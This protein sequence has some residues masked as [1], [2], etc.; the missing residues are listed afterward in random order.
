MVNI[1]RTRIK[2]DKCHVKIPKMQPKLR[3]TICDSIKHLACQKLTKSD[4]NDIIR[5]KLNWTCMECISDILPINACIPAKTVKSERP[6]I[7]KVKC[8]ACNGFCYSVKNLR[9]CDYCNS[10]VHVKCWRNGLGC[11]KCCENIIP[12]FYAYSYELIGDPYYKNNKMYNPYDSGHFTQLIGDMLCEDDESN[13]AFREASE[14]LVNCKYK[15]SGTIDVPSNLELS[16]FSLNISTLGNKIEILR[17]NISFYGNFDVLLFNETNCIVDK[18]ANGENDLELEGFYKPIIEDPIR[19]SGKGGGLSIYINKR[20]CA[21]EDDIELFCPY[22]DPENTS[23]EFQFVKIKKCKGHQKTIILGNVYRSP[24]TT[25]TKFNTYFDKILEKLNNKRYSNKLIYI[26]GDFNQ[27]LIKY[28]NDTDCQ[29]LVDSAH[30]NGFIQLVSRPTRITE[31]T[32]TLID[33]TFTNNIDSVLSCNIITADL[34]DHL[35]IQTKI[36][37]GSS[38][39]ESRTTFNKQDKKE[40]RIFTEANNQIFEQLIR[41]EKWEEIT[42][43]LGA[44]DSYDKLEEIYMKHYNTAYPLKSSRILRNHERKDPKPW[45]LPWLEDACARKNKLYY[46]FVKNPS[47]ENK[48]KYAKLDKFCK[49]HI[50]NAKIKYRK[51]YFEKYKDDSRKQWQMINE[52]LGRKRK[53]VSINKLV[54][55]NGNISSTPSSIANSFNEY[56]SK[57]ASNLKSN[58]ADSQGRNG[59]ENYHQTYLKNSVSDTLF[60]S[61]VDASEVYEVIKNFKNKSTRDTKICSLKL[62]NKSFTFTSTVASVI[63]KSFQE[64]VFPEQMKLARVTPIYKEGAKIDVGNYRPISILNS[65]SKIYEKLMHKRLSNFLESNDSIYEN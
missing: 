40:F 47:S 36:T 46:D 3:C 24:S 43:N 5:L 52:L 25:P 65:F 58:T 49:K 6:T 30:N 27:D 56:F 50:N 2:C 4:A 1:P 10:Q 14:L 64:G 11:I 62:A 12:G 17:E 29:N 39:R 48:A 38:T 55:C 61:M 53:S 44:Q 9:T 26:V 31:R 8:S 59:D 32:A 18:L 35:A 60:L 21:D 63:N 16:I 33:L 45:I 15:I 57:I 13:S 19:K 22:N 54:D 7:F 20:V 34:S 51:S 37:L 42:E 28:E 41:E 23:G